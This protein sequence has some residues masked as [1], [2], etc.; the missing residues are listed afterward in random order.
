MWGISHVF[1]A[2]QAG[3]RRCSDIHFAYIPVTFTSN[4]GVNT[5]GSIISPAPPSIKNLGLFCS[6]VPTGGKDSKYYIPQFG[7][8]PIDTPGPRFSAHR[9][10]GALWWTPQGSRCQIRPNELERFCVVVNNKHSE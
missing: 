2:W 10:R 1:S 5:F 7:P 6:T 8:D 3:T 4:D 9:K